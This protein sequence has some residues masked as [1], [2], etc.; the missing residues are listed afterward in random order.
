MMTFAEQAKNALSNSRP[1]C[2]IMR[3]KF[4]P[5]DGFKFQTNSTGEYVFYTEN[6]LKQSQNQIKQ[7][8]EKFSLYILKM[9]GDVTSASPGD[10]VVVV[11]Q[12]AKKIVKLARYKHS[13]ML[14]EKEII[15]NFLEIFS[16][17]YGEKNILLYKEVNIKN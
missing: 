16:L 17:L 10:G 15:T 11:A 9:I 7:Y 13:V 6:E 12:T 3:E 1:Y 14:H 2:L 8:Q 4:K 5:K